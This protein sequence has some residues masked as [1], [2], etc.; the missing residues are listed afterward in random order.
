MRCSKKQTFERLLFLLIIWIT[1]WIHSFIDRELCISFSNISEYR[2]NSILWNNSCKIQ[3]SDSQ[4]KLSWISYLAFLQ[5]WVIYQSSSSQSSSWGIREDKSSW[6]SSER[7]SSSFLIVLFVWVM[8]EGSRSSAL[9]I[10]KSSLS[11]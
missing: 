6:S 4:R 7:G 11:L 5:E 10:F 8:F 3:R 2:K 1:W 9:T